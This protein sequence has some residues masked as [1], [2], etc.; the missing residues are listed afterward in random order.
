MSN[1]HRFVP[2]LL[3]FACLTFTPTVHA[4]TVVVTG[5]RFTANSADGIVNFDLTGVGLR[6][7]GFGSTFGTS[8]GDNGPNKFVK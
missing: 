7:T 8:N 1:Y 6:I 4:E 2:A 5:G 3:L